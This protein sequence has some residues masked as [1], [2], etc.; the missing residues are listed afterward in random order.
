M[1]ELYVYYRVPEDAADAAAREV[2]TLHTELRASWPGLDARLLRRPDASGGQQTWM[3]VYTRSPA[4]VDAALQAEIEAHAAR[5]LTHVAGARH[6][7]VF[8]ACAS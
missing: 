3:E 8:L 6:V 7:E 4:G 2:A 1:R 5:R